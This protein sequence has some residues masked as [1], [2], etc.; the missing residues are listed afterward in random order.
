MEGGVAVA[1]EQL[2]QVVPGIDNL[3]GVVRECV[4][5]CGKDEGGSFGQKH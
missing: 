1:V 4:R 3:L 5:S 2:G